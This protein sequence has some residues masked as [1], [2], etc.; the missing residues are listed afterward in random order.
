MCF[1]HKKEKEDV[2]VQ[3]QLRMV[4]RGLMIISGLKQNIKK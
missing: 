1:T 3:N 2:V 4:G